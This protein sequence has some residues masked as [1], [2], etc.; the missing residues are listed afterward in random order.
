MDRRYYETDDDE[1]NIY[2]EDDPN[3]DPNALP[4][5]PVATSPAGMKLLLVDDKVLN[6]DDDDI[7]SEIMDS[8]INTSTIEHGD[9]SHHN[10]TTTTTTIPPH[11]DPITDTN[12]KKDSHLKII[13]V[14]SNEESEREDRKRR[15]SKIIRK[16]G[17]CWM[18]V[19]VVGIAVAG[20]VVMFRR[21]HTTVKKSSSSSSN[22]EENNNGDV[23][24]SS[25]PTSTPSM[26]PS[27][28]P[29]FIPTMYPSVSPSVLKD[30][31]DIDTT[32]NAPTGA[33]MTATP[34]A[35]PTSAAPSNSP[36]TEQFSQIMVLLRQASTTPDQFNERTTYES[37]A[38]QWVKYNSTIDLITNEKMVQRYT[39]ALLDLALHS[40]FTMALPSVDE[41]EWLGVTCN[42][43]TTDTAANDMKDV[44]LYEPVV[45]IVWN[46]Q[47]MTGAQIPNDIALLS[48]SLMHLD[49]SGN[50]NLAGTIPSGLYSCT[51]L[52]Y[53][54][55]SHTQMTGSIHSEIG[56]LS[57]L[58]KLFLGS[59]AFTGTIPAE[60]GLSSLGTQCSEYVASY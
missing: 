20:T 50:P 32:N 42:A 30:D 3:Y 46:D 34:T 17:I 45:S 39:M 16:W 55:L 37:R 54:Y 18:V 49:L 2:I 53:L 44:T 15:M 13:R 21:Y 5:T 10:T 7:I 41:C 25:F 60:L 38:A 51:Q 28:L 40:K 59:N 33:P 57:H 58:K 29:S 36:S 19:L 43:A 11:E 27:R 23:W 8:Y 52:Q 14:L 1:T 9:G 47:N 26:T 24:L 35:I 12:D 4:P 56:Q 31:T 22:V 6:Y 48:E